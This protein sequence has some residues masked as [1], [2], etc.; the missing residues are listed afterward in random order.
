MKVY[1]GSILTCDESGSV[2][3]FLVEDKGRIAF[4]GDALPVSYAGAE[5]VELG[6]GA[7]CPAFADSHIHF[8]SHALFAGGLDVRAAPDNGAMAALV[9]EYAASRKEKLIIGFG[10]SANSV[11]EKRLIERADLDRACP[12][13]PVF[14]VKYDGHAAVINGALLELLPAVLRS[15]RGFSADTGLMTQEAFFRVTD[16]VTGKV[17]LPD[18]LGR[19][20]R[21]ADAMAAK[22][23]GLIHS[24]SGVG[25]P[26][27][28]DVTLESLFAR[29][30]RNELVFR[31]YFQTLE[32]EKAVRRG[33]PRIG[34]CF[35]TALDGS[36]GSEDAALLDP[37]SGGENRGVLFYTDDKVKSFTRQANRAGLQIEMHAIGDRAV[38]Q[39]VEALSDALSDFPRKDHRHTIIHASLSRAEDLET[40]ARLGIGITLQPALLHWKQE[41]LEYLER[42]MGNRARKSSPLATMRR[43]GIHVSGG[44]DGPCSIPDPLF[45]IWAAANHF[46]EEESLSAQEALNLFTREAAWTSFDE[47][48]RGSLEP[49]KRADMTVLDRNILSIPKTQIKDAKVLRLL[50]GG[51]PYK[52]GQGRLN[53]IARGLVSRRKI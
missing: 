18:T 37:Y 25:F 6:Q 19:M 20:L 40:C 21:T 51:E 43:L 26:G 33:L 27:D 12:D 2:K 41:P 53:V 36:F 31:I 45:G 5:R 9:R 3:K 44:S 4:T 28:M 50:L 34:G 24:V 7:L 8:M 23:I 35:A 15:S 42:I 11:K 47:T 30:L 38:K 22:G 52:P 14:L 17:S 49:G 48:E 29:G 46:T 1:Q 13:R 39:A 10:A 32:V 16:F